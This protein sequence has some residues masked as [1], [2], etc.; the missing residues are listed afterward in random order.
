MGLACDSSSSTVAAPRKGSRSV[1]WADGMSGNKELLE[2]ACSQ[3]QVAFNVL[4]TK[5]GLKSKCIGDQGSSIKIQTRK[6]V[7]HCSPEEIVHKRLGIKFKC[8]AI[9]LEYCVPIHD[10]RALHTVIVDLGAE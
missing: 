10:L 5:S 7:V 4:Q 2:N 6:G 1:R 8:N 3:E 9:L